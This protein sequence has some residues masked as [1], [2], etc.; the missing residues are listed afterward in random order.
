M[1]GIA[2]RRRPDGRHRGARDPFLMEQRPERQ[3]GKAHA[4]VGKE[5]A[6]MDAMSAHL[7][8]RWTP[9]VLGGHQ[10]DVIL[11][12]LRP[13]CPIFR[14]GANVDRAIIPICRRAKVDLWFDRTTPHS[15]TLR[16]S[17]TTMR[18]IIGSALLLIGITSV[19]YFS[20]DARR[21]DPVNDTAPSSEVVTTKPSPSNPV[22]SAT[23][24][25]LRGLVARK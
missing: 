6:A 14:P 15:H 5:G 25:E 24:G 19:T 10:F 22:A 21:E 23:L 16:Q 18:T 1:M 11:A 9:T 2:R 13:A 12:A 3:A 8:P 17:R 20:N 7:L 4:E